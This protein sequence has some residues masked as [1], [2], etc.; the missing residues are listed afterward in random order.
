MELALRGYSKFYGTKHGNRVLSWA[1]Y[2]GTA[3]LISCFPKG[4][5]EL[6]VSL[7]QATVLLLFNEKTSWKA[8]E[9]QEATGLNDN[10]LTLTLQSL[11]L[12]KK[13][14]LTKKGSTGKA[15]QKEDLFTFNAEFTDAKYKVH[16]NSI[17]QNE[18]VSFTLSVT[19]LVPSPS[20]EN[21][22]AMTRT[23]AL[24]DNR[25]KKL[26]TQPKSLISLAKPHSM[27]R[28]FAL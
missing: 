1:Q 18:S 21:S 12:G 22:P 25:R 17:Q 2:L 4:N 3:T 27:L 20:L 11:A 23:Y 13:R 6:S 7:Y 16:V 14:V 9:I 19:P 26:N 28:L 15:V 10:D 5:K 24:N 8:D